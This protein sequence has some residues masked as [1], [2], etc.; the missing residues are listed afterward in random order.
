MI[1]TYVNRDE[2]IKQQDTTNSESKKKTIEE[3]YKIIIG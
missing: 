3:I 2:A 1:I